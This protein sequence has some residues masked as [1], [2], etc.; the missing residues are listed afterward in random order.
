MTS[1]NHKQVCY[2]LN[3]LYIL[4]NADYGDSFHQSWKDYGL[5]MAAIRIGDKY[6]RLKNLAAGKNVPNIAEETVRDTLMDMAN[7]AILTVMELDAESK[8]KP[9]RMGGNT[10]AER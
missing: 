4:K 7:Y 2:Q 3:D 8:P 6:N 1:E 9:M 10:R 5:I